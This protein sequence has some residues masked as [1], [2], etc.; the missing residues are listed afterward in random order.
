MSKVVTANELATGLVVF[1]S[2]D[3][4]WTHDLSHA[5]EFADDA[6]AQD[7]LAGAKADEAKAIIVDPFVTDKEE[8]TGERPKMTLRDTIRAFGPTIKF[9]PADRGTGSNA[10]RA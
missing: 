1:L 5:R 8:R 4:G 6:A 10:A 9:L 3:G 2:T 7:G